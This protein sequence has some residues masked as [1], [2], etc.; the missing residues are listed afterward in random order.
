MQLRIAN[1]TV[2]TRP[3]HNYSKGI[4]AIALP[5][6][7]VLIRCFTQLRFF[8]DFSLDC[9]VRSCRN[10]NCYHNKLNKFGAKDCYVIENV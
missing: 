8:E 3:C 9:I 7:F 1:F 10:I 2:V 5:N 6:L 4:P